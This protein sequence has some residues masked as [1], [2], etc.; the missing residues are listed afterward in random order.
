MSDPWFS[1][2]LAWLPGT[3]LGCMAGLFG[4]LA[5]C[6]APRGKAKGLVLNGLWVLLIISVILLAAGGAALIVGQPY[7]VWYGLGLAGMIGTL[8]IGF[9]LPMI[10][11][12][13]RQAE[14]R[15]ME[16]QDLG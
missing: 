11:R 6:C 2:Y 13:Y 8:V 4:G 5:G 1:E 12:V 9:N 10:I 14:M 7:A 16:A 15:K 3:V